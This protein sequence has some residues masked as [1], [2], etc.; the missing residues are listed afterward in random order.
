MIVKEKIEINGTEFNKQ[1][2][3]EGYYIER[4][5]SLFSEAIDPID[6]DR[7]YI[8]TDIKIKQNTI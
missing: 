6:V 7:R 4:D 5:G 1:Y 3:D 8:E 2:S